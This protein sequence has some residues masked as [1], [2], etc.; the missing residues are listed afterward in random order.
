MA[1]TSVETVHEDKDNA[2]A[3]ARE[4]YERAREKIRRDKK[5][6]IFRGSAD[7]IGKQLA[8]CELL[9]RP[10]LAADFLAPLTQDCSCNMPC[11]ADHQ[12][13]DPAPR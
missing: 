10:L 12:Y 3:L 9:P 2:E 11:S 5:N 7:L 13:S 1:F 6:K 8:A 4:R